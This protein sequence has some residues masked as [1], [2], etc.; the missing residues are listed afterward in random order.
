MG[1]AK[2][3]DKV[4]WHF[5][6]G[7]G[8]PSLEAAKLHFSIIMEWLK[9]KSLL[10]SEGL[11]AYGNGIDAEF[12]LTTHML[13]PDGNKILGECYAMW[14]RTIEYGVRPSTGLLDRCLSATR[15]T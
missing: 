2:T 5:P 11:E 13:N 7:K 10:S 12:S 8:C 9:E 14:A 6:E 4:S 15:T 1:L 3:Y